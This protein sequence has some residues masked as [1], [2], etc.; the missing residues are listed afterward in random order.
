MCLQG[1]H[2][3]FLEFLKMKIIKAKAI[4]RIWELSEKPGNPFRI[5]DIL[6]WQIGSGEDDRPIPL[7]I[8][9]RHEGPYVMT[10]GAGWLAW[11]SDA[12]FQSSRDVEQYLRLGCRTEEPKDGSKPR[13]IE[14]PPG[15]GPAKATPE[16]QGTSGRI[17]WVLARRL[18]TIRRYKQRSATIA[19]LV[20][21]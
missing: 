21:K 14:M 10:T 1:F 4:H 12:T 16:H 3:N 5:T 6:A 13:S 15:I 7:T 20:C 2:Q 17:A 11:P 9:G 8:H 19:L 18:E